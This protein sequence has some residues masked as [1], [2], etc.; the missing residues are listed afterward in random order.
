MQVKGRSQLKIFA[1]LNELELTKKT[2]FVP[3]LV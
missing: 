1:I 2:F 3:K